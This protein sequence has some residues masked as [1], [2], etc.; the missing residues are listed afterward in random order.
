MTVRRKYAG[1]AAQRD[2]YSA[3]RRPLRSPSQ[4]TSLALAALLRFHVKLHFPMEQKRSKWPRRSF[5]LF[6]IRPAPRFVASRR[7]QEV[8]PH[9]RKKIKMFRMTTARLIERL[10]RD[11]AEESF[12]GCLTPAA[13]LF[14]LDGFRKSSAFATS[15][16]STFSCR[17]C[18]AKSFG[19]NSLRDVM[20][21]GLNSLCVLLAV[22]KIEKPARRRYTVSVLP[23]AD[24]LVKLDVDV[25]G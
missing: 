3:V 13:P 1:K 19:L 21:I 25:S 18:S 6:R 24:S 8:R 9:D 23:Q 10:Y 11:F 16:R 7:T 17:N 5:T 2:R 22:S 14:C 4:L 15:A 12:A 20:I